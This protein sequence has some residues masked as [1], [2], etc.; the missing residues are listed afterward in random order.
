MYLM[1]GP[2]Y[3]PEKQTL[4][5]RIE[6][7]SLKTGELIYKEIVLCTVLDLINVVDHKIFAPMK[8]N[9]ILMANV[10]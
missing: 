6:S 9:V 1:F 3:L 8:C 4:S 7:S 5:R 10:R 2:A